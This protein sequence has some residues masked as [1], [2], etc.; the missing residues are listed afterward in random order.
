MEIVGVTGPRF[1]RHLRPVIRMR[2]G[3]VNSLTT[4]WATLGALGL[5][6]N[7][8]EPLKSTILLKKTIWHVDT[9]TMGAAGH[10]L[11]P[12]CG[13]SMPVLLNGAC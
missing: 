7:G 9:E 11:S 6:G 4:S 5:V 12:A 10:G 8:W 13:L 1:Y 2:S 3:L